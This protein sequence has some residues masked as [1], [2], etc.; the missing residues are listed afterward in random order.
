MGTVEE[1]LCKKRQPKALMHHTRDAPSNKNIAKLYRS[2]KID[3][4]VILNEALSILF[5]SFNTI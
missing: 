4:L 5:K 2:I 3:V 1:N